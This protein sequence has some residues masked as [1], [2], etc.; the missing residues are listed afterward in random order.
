MKY[1]FATSYETY[2]KLISVFLDIW[3]CIWAY[4][5]FL[6]YCFRAEQELLLRRSSSYGDDKSKNRKSL[7]RR[8]K[9]GSSHHAINHSRESSDSK[10]DVESTVSG[11]TSFVFIPGFL[12]VFFFYER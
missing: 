11:G 10:A 4:S 3:R 9:K 6:F 8:S 5:F 2:Q 12:F 1:F 7:F